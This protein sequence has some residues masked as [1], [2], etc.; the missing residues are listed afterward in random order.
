MRTLITMILA[1]VLLS[2]ALACATIP[3][4]DPDPVKY[5]NL[6]AEVLGLD[7]YVPQVEYVSRVFQIYHKRGDRFGE[8]PLGIGAENLVLDGDDRVFEHD[9]SGV[10][11]LVGPD[12]EIPLTS[13]RVA[14]P[15]RQFTSFLLGR[16][17]VAPHPEIAADLEFLGDGM[18]GYILGT[19]ML[20]APRRVR[21]GDE[22]WLVSRSEPG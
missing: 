13:A 1:L 10:V 12:G 14:K 3:D 22:A 7:E 6:A 5:I 16:P 4:P 15:C 17:D 8:V 2:T 20:D 18:R 21:R 11:V 9:L 19:E